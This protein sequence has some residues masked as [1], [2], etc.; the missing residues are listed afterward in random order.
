M[1]TFAKMSQFWRGFTNKQERYNAR[2]ILHEKQIVVERVA[3]NMWTTRNQNN[4]K[5]YVYLFSKLH[6]DRRNT[7]VQISTRSC[8]GRASVVQGIS[9]EFIRLPFIYWNSRNTNHQ[10]RSHKHLLGKSWEQTW[11]NSTAIQV[12]MICASVTIRFEVKKFLWGTW[13][14]FRSCSGILIIDQYCATLYVHVCSLVARGC[15]YVHLWR[16][17]RTPPMADPP[18]C[19]CSPVLSKT[20]SA[21]LKKWSTQIHDNCMHCWMM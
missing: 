20:R 4:L 9:L 19:P 3:L 18:R 10:V 7:Q 21:I 13:F 5:Y 11:H 14:F 8:K 15:Q 2:A 1:V 6:G 17:F 16:I 12:A